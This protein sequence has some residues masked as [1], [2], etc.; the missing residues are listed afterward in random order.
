MNALQRL[1]NLWRMSEIE[2]PPTATQ[3]RNDYIETLFPSKKL[4]TIIDME[5]KPDEFVKQ[6]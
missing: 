6:A 2:L 5:D 3:K 1:K 4:A